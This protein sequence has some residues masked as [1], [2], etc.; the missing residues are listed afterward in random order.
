MNNDSFDFNFSYV[1]SFCAVLQERINI[2]NDYPE[3]IS[4]D[5]LKKLQ[6]IKELTEKT[7][8]LMKE[9]ECYFDCAD[10][11]DEGFQKEVDPIL[12]SVRGLFDKKT[13]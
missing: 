4:D 2:I 1:D 13:K 10:S 12:E 9:T 7:A 5:V 11:T 6:L 3:D 8:L